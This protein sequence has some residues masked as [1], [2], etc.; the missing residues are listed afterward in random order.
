[1]KNN[2][3]ILWQNLNYIATPYMITETV[4]V[5]EMQDHNYSIDILIFL[6]SLGNGDE[7]GDLIP[8]VCFYTL[9]N[10]CNS[11]KMCTFG[12]CTYIN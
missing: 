6:A 7:A 5:F 10:S 1:M 2:S 3:D 9:P 8:N 4:K 12:L 11:S